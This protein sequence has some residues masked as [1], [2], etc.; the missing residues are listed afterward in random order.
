MIPWKDNHIQFAR[1]LAEI[2]GKLDGPTWASV[3]EEMDIRPGDL[4]ELFNRAEIEWIR[5]KGG[6]TLRRLTPP[7]EVESFTR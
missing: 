2:H 1:L 6:K 7:S 5:I 4:E 3:C